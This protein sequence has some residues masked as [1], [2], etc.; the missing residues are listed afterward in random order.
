MITEKEARKIIG[1]DGAGALVKIVGGAWK[2]FVDEGVKRSP[3]AR[4]IVVWDYMIEEAEKH[5]LGKFDG[6]ERVM[7]SKSPAYVLRNRIL[8]RFKKHDHDM[9][10]KNIPTELQKRIA[11]NGY[12]DGMP[13][14]AV[15]TCGYVLDKAEAG[16]EKIVAAR[17]ISNVS[18]WHIDLSELAA[19][20]LAPTKP[21]IPRIG[22][23]EEVASLPSIARVAR[24][25]DGDGA[26]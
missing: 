18:E 22:G 23:S 13:G 14:L 4:A 16:I 17:A 19:G 20:V 8:L 3:A 15:L 25:E 2:R 12:F 1:I 7:L 10:T 5:L 6:V 26:K 24:K 9:L 21:I 11:K